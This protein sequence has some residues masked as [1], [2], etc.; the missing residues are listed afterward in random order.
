MAAGLIL[1]NRAYLAPYDT[2]A[3]QLVLFIVCGIFTAG[4]FLLRSLSQVRL[5][6]HFARRPA[7]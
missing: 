5:S 2:P 4:F 1:L 3:G 7:T 6:G